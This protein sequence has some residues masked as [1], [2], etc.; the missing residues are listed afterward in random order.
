M[1]ETYHHMENSGLPRCPFCDFSHSD[2]DYL[3]Q[4]VNLRHPENGVSPFITNEE[5]QDSRGGHRRWKR[6]TTSSVPSGSDDDEDDKD[7]VEC[8]A[9]CG[10]AITIVELP[11]HMELHAAEDM[12]WDQ[13]D[14]LPSHDHQ[15]YSS[16]PNQAL[17]KTLSITA[18]SSNAESPRLHHSQ[19][20]RKDAGGLSSL[21]E[22][23]LGNPP[24]GSRSAVR[25]TRTGAVRRLGVCPFQPQS[26]THMANVLQRAELGPHAYEEQMPVWLRKQLEHGENVVLTNQIGSCGKFIRVESITNQITG[27]IPVIAQLSE[28]D[29]SV[30]Q[31]FLCHPSVIHV[32]KTPKEGGFCGYRNIQMLISYIRA[33]EAP[34]HEAFQS[35]IPSILEI[36]DLIESAWDKGIN[37]TGK[38]ETGGIRGT[39]KYIGTPEVK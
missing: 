19:K 22:L 29:P 17:P 3:V 1:R 30:S 25:R 18:K 9:K 24:K 33:T 36:Q 27:I 13:S 14:Y 11:S 23:I 4:H 8:P 21:M 5:S 34:G 39:R 7:F 26:G 31:V 37:S 38:I 28:Q 35:K 6:G 20:K 32:T 10:E 12:T 16:S 15:P 2:T